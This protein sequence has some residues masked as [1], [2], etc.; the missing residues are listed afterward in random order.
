M[1]RIAE[2]TPA[3]EP[4]LWELCEKYITEGLGKENVQF[5]HYYEE[6]LLGE[7]MDHGEM[8]EEFARRTFE[9]FEDARKSNP[10]VIFV[11]CSTIGNVSAAAKKLYEQ[12]GVKLISGDEPAAQKAVSVGERIGLIVNLETTLGPSED[13]LRRCA[14]EQGKNIEIVLG[15]R[16][17]F[18]MGKDQI[19]QA[20]YDCCVEVAP[21]VDVI[22]LAQ[23]SMSLYSDWLQEAVDVPVISTLPYAVDELKKYKE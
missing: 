10:D 11:E 3:K 9:I 7:I 23:P 2:V 6:K 15:Y 16:K 20:V 1:I 22:F 4:G 13:L 14:A 21:E 8:T 17:V 18:G 5:E 19:K 12:M